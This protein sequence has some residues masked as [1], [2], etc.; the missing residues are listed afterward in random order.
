MKRALV[1]GCAGFIGS[2]LCERL[3]AEGFDVVG[4]DGFTPYYDRADKLSNLGALEGSRR[5]TLVEADLTTADLA[6]ML[7]D[8]PLVFHLAAQPGVRL[9]F[10]DGFARYTEDNMV[11]TQRVLEAAAAAGC[12]RVVWASSSSVYG[13][14]A[15]YPCIEDETPTAPRSP[16]GVTKRACEDLAAI[17]RSGGLPTVGLRYFTVYGP[18]QRPDMAMRRLC[19]ALLG[20]MSFPLYGDGSQS[21]DF[22]H[23]ADAV[24]ATYRAALARDPAPIYNVGGGHEATLAEVISVLEHLAGRAAVLDRRPAQAGDVLRTAAETSRARRDLGWAPIVGLEEGLRSQLD[25][26]ATRRAQL[27]AAAAEPRH[28]ITRRRR[29]QATRA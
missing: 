1:T 12:R 11:A 6:P 15:A 25:W 26:V 9:S 20:G 16:Y 23:V 19:E 27:A 29:A 13:D 8:A 22:T 28:R 2:H 7:A 21:R 18:R 5:F 4:V 14:A 10:G 3:V 17:A 24:D